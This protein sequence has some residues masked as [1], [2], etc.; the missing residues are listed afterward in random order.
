MGKLG[1]QFHF[2]R[3]STRSDPLEDE[4]WGVIRIW[5]DADQDGITDQG[6]LYTLAGVEAWEWYDIN[7]NGAQDA[8]EYQKLENKNITEIGLTYDDWSGY[9]AR[10]DDITVLGN[11]LYCVSSDKIERDTVGWYRQMEQVG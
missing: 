1:K 8:G 7:G 3:A 9:A 5:Q 6:E 2:A 10:D 4:R 11:I